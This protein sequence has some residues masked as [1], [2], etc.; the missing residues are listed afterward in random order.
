MHTFDDR[1]KDLDSKLSNITMLDIDLF[2]F[3]IELEKLEQSQETDLSFFENLHEILMSL[4]ELQ[5]RVSD[6]PK[7]HFKEAAHNVLEAYLNNIEEQHITMPLGEQEIM[8]KAV[9]QMND[10]LSGNLNAVTIESLH[11]TNNEY[12]GDI[13]NYGQQYAV[14]RLLQEC[15]AL[16][17][18]EDTLA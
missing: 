18:H 17:A 8:M 11:K 6:L 4:E 14:L 10:L 16:V 7:G 2:D 1:Y 12:A 3:R 9:Q 15:L 5:F 13:V